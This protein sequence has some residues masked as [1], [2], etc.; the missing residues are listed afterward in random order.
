MALVFAIPLFTISAITALCLSHLPV[1]NGLITYNLLSPVPYLF[2]DTDSV[3]ALSCNLGFVINGS[4]TTKC[5]TKGIWEPKLGS[6]VPI[7]YALANS[8]SPNS[9]LTCERMS[10]TMGTITYVP[11]F[12]DNAVA[13]LTCP[14]GQRV[15]GGATHVT[16]QG[17]KWSAKFG[18]CEKVN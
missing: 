12:Q 3:A 10:A 15:H 1:P 9:N 16:C 7:S 13:M 17:G 11:K 2:H 14:F 18:N 4:S 6:C 5:T 8:S